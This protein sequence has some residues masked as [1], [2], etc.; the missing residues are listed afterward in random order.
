MEDV[1][2]EKETEFLQLYIDDIKNLKPE[3]EGEK[4]ELF[5]R[6]V[7]GD[8]TASERLLELYLMKAVQTASKYCG[9]GLSLAD[10]IQEA[11]VALLLAFSEL[12]SMDKANDSYIMEY[13][14]NYIK[15]AVWAEQNEKASAGSLADKI[16]FLSD[17]TKE[18]A[19]RFGREAT[20]EEIKE[21]TKLTEDEI[22]ALMKMSLDAL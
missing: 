14:E 20:L 2:K 18:L 10:L 12:D 17:V 5:E 1:W 3:R 7:G 16:N 21:Y 22:R 8:N 19:E 4:Q 15:Q 13:V 11:N 9:Q 6:C